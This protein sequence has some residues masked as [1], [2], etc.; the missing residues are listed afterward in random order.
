MGTP[1]VYDV[2]E[3]L[4]RLGWESLALVANV[5]D[6]PHPD[7][8]GKVVE[9]LEE[10]WRSLPIFFPLLTPGYRKRLD[11]ELAERSFRER[12]SL[13][14]PTAIVASTAQVLPGAMINAGALLAAKVRVGRQ[15]VVNRSASIGHHTHLEDYATIGPG[16]VLCGSC[17]IERGAFLGGGCVVSPE[18]TVGANAIVGAGAVVTRDVPPNSV[19]VGNPARVLRSDI[20]GYNDVGV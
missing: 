17:R 19:V 1:Y 12:A 11:E 2:F 4:Q 8:L 7:D 15:A 20:A 5:P 3:S 10:G 18:R 14:D 6:A 13:I 16:C 9:R